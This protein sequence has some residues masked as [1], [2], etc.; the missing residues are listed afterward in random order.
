MT[1]LFEAV[2]KLTGLPERVYQLDPIS[3][4]IF[5]Y[6]NWILF[7]ISLFV[8]VYVVVYSLRKRFKHEQV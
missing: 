6:Y 1:E 8:I 4:F 3:L 7:A 5:T 2:P